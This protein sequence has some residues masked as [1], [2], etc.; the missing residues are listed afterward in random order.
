M[1]VSASQVWINAESVKYHMM[2][3]SLSCGLLVGQNNTFQEVNLD[4]ETSDKHFCY[5]VF[6]YV[7][8]W[9]RQNY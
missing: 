6:Y 2:R 3:L 7:L 1:P 9:Y 8:I 4:L 5:F